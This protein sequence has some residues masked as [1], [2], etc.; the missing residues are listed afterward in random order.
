MSADEKQLREQLIRVAYANPELR[1]DLL[2][3]LKREAQLSD[4]DVEEGK[5]HRILGLDE[6]QNISEYGSPAA[7][8]RKI[9][10]EMGEQEA[11]SMINWA[12]NISGDDFLER[13]QEELKRID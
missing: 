2:P 12:A 11:A 5:M 10:N 7:A 3:L 6:D 4:V 9:V 8:T 13:M 1:G